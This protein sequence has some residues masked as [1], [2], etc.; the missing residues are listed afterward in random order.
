M[1]IPLVSVICICHNHE[2][3]VEEAIYSVIDQTY[4]NIEIILIDDC[5]IDNSPEIIEKLKLKI[6][7]IQAIIS[8]LNVGICKAFNIGLE[9]AR[10]D[11]IIDLS[12]DDILL[13]DRI[14]DGLESLNNKG[15]QY[16]VNFTDAAY[17]DDSGKILDYHYRRK[18]NGQLIEQIPEG[19]I[20]E[21][22]LARYFI[23][24]PTM[25]IRKSI[26]DQLGGYDEDLFYEDFDFW[27]RSGKMT[28]Y[29]FTDKVLVKKRIMKDSLST[30]QYK[31]NSQMLISTY[32]VCLKAEQLNETDSERL[33]LIQRIQ[34]ELRKA[35]LS[36]NY[37][38][39][40]DFANLLIRNRKPGIK[41]SFMTV[42]KEILRLVCRNKD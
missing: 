13:P 42:I 37:Q 40:Y 18:K 34:F 27:I 4:P 6:P 23:C 25:L 8:D 38:V 22:L 24:T 11:Y 30:R 19:Y 35:L 17:I 20:Y 5:S 36:R 12:A 3:F 29:C 16:G 9:K 2:S 14:T 39:A 10:G 31:R 33:A 21:K 28:K 15:D 41:K 26:F 32:K 1:Q 7:Q